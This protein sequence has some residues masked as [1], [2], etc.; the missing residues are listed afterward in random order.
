MMR[1]GRSSVVAF[2]GAALCGVVMLSVRDGQDGAAG[3]GG[4][5]VLGEERLMVDPAIARAMNADALR[6]QRN[7]GGGAAL[8]DETEGTR[9]WSRVRVREMVAKLFK[10]VDAINRRITRKDDGLSS[11]LSSFSKTTETKAGLLD[12]MKGEAAGVKDMVAKQDMAAN[13]DGALAGRVKGAGKELS[14]VR[15]SEQTMRALIAA[16][17]SVDERQLTHLEARDAALAATELSDN[18]AA[19]SAN[20]AALSEARASM[21]AVLRAEG[22]QH[23]LD[24]WC[25]SAAAKCPGGGTLRATQTLPALAWACMPGGGGATAGG[26][27]AG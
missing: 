22:V 11:K 26:A 8:D 14:V 9:D 27:G 21:D 4:P 19:S 3:A 25:N 6:A 20:M 17:D 23:H 15:K 10:A 18:N 12:A 2:L 7:E 13:Q 16:Q 24:A 1:L 5:S